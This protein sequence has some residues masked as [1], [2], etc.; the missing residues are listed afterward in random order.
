MFGSYL[1]QS[2]LR[3]SD[4]AGLDVNIGIELS[5]ELTSQIRNVLSAEPDTK[6]PDFFGLQAA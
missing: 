5:F 4:F 1:L 6:I 2:Q 3:T